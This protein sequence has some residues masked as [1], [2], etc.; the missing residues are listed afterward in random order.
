MTIKTNTEGIKK[1]FADSLA[2]LYSLTKRYDI[3]LNNS[4]DTDNDILIKLI[5]SFNLALKFLNRDFRYDEDEFSFFISKE[6]IT[7]GDPVGICD[8][9]YDV[10]VT[11]ADGSSVKY[12][13]EGDSSNGAILTAIDFATDDYES[14]EIRF[15]KILSQRPL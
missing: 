8:Y 7:E 15:V 5:N 4:E 6:T 12:Q 10:E 9:E 2:N 3:D 11:F 1:F 14:K 13:I